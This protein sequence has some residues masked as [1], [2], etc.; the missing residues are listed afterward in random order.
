MSSKLWMKKCFTLLVMAFFVFVSVSA[1]QVR[2]SGKVTDASTQETLPGVNVAIKGTSM[3]TST[4][5]YGNYSISV[6]R[7]SIL[8]FS[9]LGYTPQEITVGTATTINVALVPEA[10]ELGEVVVTA[11]GI[12]RAQKSLGYAVST[13]NAK[14]ITKVGTTNFGSALYGKAA[15]VQIRTAPGGATSAVDIKIR[16][17]NSINF[18]SQPLIVVDG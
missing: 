2:I 6:N 17:L 11:L 18:S 10:T 4:D 9:F 1:Q 13:I 7:G 14:E 16:G 12:R 5:A 8:L 3:G 15:G